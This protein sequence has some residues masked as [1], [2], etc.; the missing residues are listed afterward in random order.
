VVG[1]SGRFQRPNPGRGR[2]AYRPGQPAASAGL[3][4]AIGSSASAGVS[5]AGSQEAVVGLVGDIRPPQPDPWTWWPSVTARTLT[6]NLSPPRQRRQSAASAPSATQGSEGLP[7]RHW[8]TWRLINPTNRISSPSSRPPPSMAF[9][10]PLVTRFSENGSADV[11]AGQ[12][13]LKWGR[14]LAKE[15]RQQSLPVHSPDLDSTWP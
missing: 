1:I 5:L 2:A 8:P 11:G 15:R 12:E 9:R 14:T 10:R 13:S 7:P 4:P 3:V 6:L